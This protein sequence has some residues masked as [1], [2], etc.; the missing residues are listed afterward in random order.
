MKTY[1]SEEETIELLVREEN[2]VASGP[3]EGP[4]SLNLV[5]EVLTWLKKCFSLVRISM[6]MWTLYLLTIFSF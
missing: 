5:Q 4:V 3:N 2:D 1:E 6:L